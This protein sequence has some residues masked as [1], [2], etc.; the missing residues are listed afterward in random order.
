MALRI[1]IQGNELLLAPGSKL[2]I[3]ETNPFLQTDDALQGDFSYPLTVPVKGNEKA[4]NYNHLLQIRGKSDPI[5]NV[6]VSDDVE[7]LSGVLKMDKVNGNINGNTKDNINVYFLPGISSFYQDVLNLT[8]QDVDYG[9]DRTFQFDHGNA[10]N[11]TGLFKHLQEVM[12]QG[13]IDTFDYAVYEIY[14]TNLVNLTSNDSIKIFN[15]IVANF[16]GGDAHH[17]EL[18]SS[19]HLAVFPYINYLIQRIFAS[20][21]WT[22]DGFIFDDLDFKKVNLINVQEIHPAFSTFG[23]DVPGQYSFNLKRIVPPVLITTFLISLKNRFGWWYD[24]DT[25]RRHCTI[26][27]VRDV[28]TGDKR[29]DITNQVNSNFTLTVAASA[30]LYGVSADEDEPDKTQWDYRGVLAVF[31]LLPAASVTYSGQVFFIAARNKYYICEADVNGVYNW[32]ELQENDFGIIPV[33][34]TGSTDTEDTISTNCLIPVVRVMASPSIGIPGT[35]AIPAVSLDDANTTSDSFYVCFAHGLAPVE[36]NPNLFYTYGSP[37]PYDLRGNK[38]TSISL[39]YEWLEPATGKDLGLY[40]LFW[41]T[42]LEKLSAEETIEIITRLTPQ[43]IISFTWDTTYLIQNTEY[44]VSQ[45]NRN[46]AYDGF[47]TLTMIRI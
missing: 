14:H 10:I 34:P 6:I 5:N 30:T 1:N 33:I 28:F 21:N 7:F 22:V 24:F 25:A 19:V 40:E 37:H 18:G 17:P 39:T 8:L 35:M 11:D 9:P 3:E 15:L 44:I 2:E 29:V 31:N 43:Q 38:L 26:R 32:D 20:Y 46:I 23:N 47:V 4:L 41:R 16:Q 27:K 13:T 12:N 45:R 42:F 36:E